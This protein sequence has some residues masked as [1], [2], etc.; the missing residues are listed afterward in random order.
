[1]LTQGQENIDFVQYWED[2]GK[3]SFGHP[4]LRSLHD[5][6]VLLAYYAGSPDCMSIQWARVRV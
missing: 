5:G 1:M 6:R 4:A 3:W 2:M